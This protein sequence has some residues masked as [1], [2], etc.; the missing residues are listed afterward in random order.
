METIGIMLPHKEG[1]TH[2]D[3][4]LLLVIRLRR[5]WRI[6]CHSRDMVKHD[7]DTKIHVSLQPESV[8]ILLGSGEYGGP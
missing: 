7:S 2:G 1:T 8:N 6:S 5:L 4:P 3:E